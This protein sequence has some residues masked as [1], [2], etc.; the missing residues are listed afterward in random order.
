[1]EIRNEQQLH[2][3]ADEVSAITAVVRPILSG[4]LFSLKADVV[5]E[6][7]GREHVK[8]KMLPRLRRAGDGDTGICF[9]YAA[10]DAVRRQEPRVAERVYDA[11][12]LCNVPG[13]E[14][15][16]ILFGAEKQGSQQLIDTAAAL[17][18]EESRLLSGYRGQPVKLRRHLSAAAAAFR[19]KGIVSDLPQSISGLWRADLFLG[20]PDADRW[21]GTTV[22]INRADLQ[23]DRGLRVAVVPAT[24]G[25]SD[26]LY[27]DEQRNL[28]VCP[29][30]Y[31]GSF[32]ET[33]Y[34][35]WEVVTQFL[36]ADAHVPKEVALSRP[37]A[38]TVARYLADRREF[39]VVDV[40]EAL[41][42]LA[43]PELLTTE[44]SSADVVLS[45]GKSKTVETASVLAPT[46]LIR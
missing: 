17:L 18:T 7:G 9:E 40:I 34:K 42:P 31:D 23:G 8:L 19:R 12:A 1:M 39:P 43:Q 3:V 16:S 33:F 5:A 4:I 45:G 30:P 38:R 11:L 35:A 22:K 14:V 25:R 13:K 15:G 24:E 46:P 20:S 21:V 26:K 41:G 10:H 28:V 2:A 37:P 29:L 32:V 6:A 27:K 44:S 36:A